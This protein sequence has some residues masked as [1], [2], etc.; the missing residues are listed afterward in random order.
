MALVV[1]RSG[2]PEVLE[3]REVPAPEP[4]AGEILLRARAFGVQWA[5]LLEREGRY[6]GGPQPPFVAGHD[7]V[8]DVVSVGPGVD[9]PPVGTRV[10]GAVPRGGAAAELV[11]VPA[12]WMHAVPDGVSDE[13]AAA[14]VSPYF[15]ADAA[16]ITLGRFEPGETVLVHAAAGSFGSAAVQLCRAYGAST[17]VGTAGSDEKLKRVAEFGAD[18]VVNYTTDDFVSAVLDATDGRGVDLVVESVGGDILGRCLDCI[19]PGGRLVSVGASS[20]ESSKRFRLQTLF[21]KGILVGGFTLG[22][23][24]EHEPELVRP[25][26]ERVLDLLRRGEIAPVIGAVF[27]PTSAADAHRYLE[28]RQSVGRTVISLSPAPQ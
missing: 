13:T 20:G 5:D 8:G 27:E 22:L 2:G 10:F 4:A 17:I 7:V 23:W 21:E 19:R 26:A 9:S 12:S 1:T 6:P 25:S 14:V 18:V 16:I 11:A 3:W 15:T 28:N 24:V